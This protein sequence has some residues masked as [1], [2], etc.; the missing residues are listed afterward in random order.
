MPISCLNTGRSFWR[1]ME[2]T[3]SIGSMILLLFLM[4]I[5][6]ILGMVSYSSSKEFN[7]ELCKSFGID[8][9]EDDNESAVIAFQVLGM[10]C[11]V[12]VG[13][14]I[15]YIYKRSVSNLDWVTPT[16]IGIIGI[17]AFVLS[18]VIGNS[19]QGGND[20]GNADPKIREWCYK[21]NETAKNLNITISVFM[22]ISI[23]VFIAW[24]TSMV[25]N[26]CE[27]Y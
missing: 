3:I 9:L 10:V 5:S 12:L 15:W 4:L 26:S 20:D 27:I 14:S 19:S 22:G 23:A 2:Q 13:M 1:S 16:I 18:A 11:V 7:N 21:T 8:K 24:F 6:P 25:A 17:V